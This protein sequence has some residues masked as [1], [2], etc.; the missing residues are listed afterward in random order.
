MDELISTAEAAHRLGVKTATLYAYVSRGVLRSVRTPDGSRFDP[1]EVDALAGRGRATGRPAGAVETVRS[2][3]TSLD[4]HRLRY[5]GQDAVALSRE[6]TFEEVARL[7]WTGVAA[8][9]PFVAQEPLTAAVRA[10]VAGLPEQVRPPARLRVA[11]AVCGALAPTAPGASPE[12][13]LAAVLGALA[14]GTTTAGTVAAVL[15]TTIDLDPALVLLADHGLAVSTVAARVAASARA[16]LSSVLAAALG[17]SDGPLHASAGT[18]AHRFLTRALTDGP[19]RAVAEQRR[20]G[21][22]P[23]GFGHVVHTERDP[24]ADELLA[25]LPAGPV[26]DVVPDLVGQVVRAHGA[27]AFPNVDLGLAALALAHDLPP[28]AGELVFEVA[29]TAGWIAHALEEYEA[30]GLRFRVRGLHGA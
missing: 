3:L 1:G 15:G 7:L 20:S 26:A 22:P 16:P 6:R 28:D 24:R 8:P 11:V 27:R 13:L 29:R 14:P 2:R 10:V 12:P 18:A 5:R 25:R 19:A 21:A 4:G 9:G 30:P 17:A 23:P